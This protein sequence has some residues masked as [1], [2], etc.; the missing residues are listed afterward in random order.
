MTAEELGGP[1]DVILSDPP[2]RYSFSR[3]ESRR[4]ERHY[5]TLTM[6]EIM[7]MRDGVLSVAAPDAVLCMWAT[8]PKLAEALRVM[9]WWQFEYRTGLIW[10][11]IGGAPGMG[12]YNRT[13]HEHLLIGTR[14]RPG[15]PRPAT[16]ESSVLRAPAGR[17]S[18]KPTEIQGRI[19]R[20]WPDARRLE[21]FGRHKRP[22]WTV[23]GFDVDGADLRD[24]MT[25]L[26]AP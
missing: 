24:L 3:S 21:L 25:T 15:V 14:G 19:E 7:D 26:G 16:R 9:D 10:H 20:Y 5:P 23:L 1:F 17:H 18:E 13:D 2:W 8:A 22:G 6:Y 11:K 12:H 4:V